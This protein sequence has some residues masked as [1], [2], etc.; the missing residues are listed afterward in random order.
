MLIWTIQITTRG[1]ITS[2]E[3]GGHPVTTVLMSVHAG[4]NGQ[5]NP[6]HITLRLW[7]GCRDGKGILYFSVLGCTSL[8]HMCVWC[9]SLG[10][11]IFL[12]VFAIFGTFLVLI[13]WGFLVWV[14]LWL[15]FLC[16]FFCCAGSSANWWCLYCFFSWL[17]GDFFAWL[18]VCFCFNRLYVLLFGSLVLF[19][20]FWPLLLGLPLL[21]FS[22]YLC[23]FGAGGV[24]C[25]IWLV[26]G[27]VPDLFSLR[28]V[29]SVFV[30]LQSFQLIWLVKINKYSFNRRVS[31]KWWYTIPTPFFFLLEVCAWWRHSF[32]SRFPLNVPS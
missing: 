30:N 4:N 12:N 28:L 20:K 8:H 1:N 22:G 2:P 17:A 10:V 29:W 26:Y 7:V 18:G 13:L 19:V 9:V 11:V 21:P 25:C 23:W 3:G 32:K 14:A 5:N 16:R 6:I 27:L 31:S 24:L 15:V